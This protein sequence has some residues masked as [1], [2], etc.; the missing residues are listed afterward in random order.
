MEVHYSRKSRPLVVVE[1]SNEQPTLSDS[2]SN[3]GNYTAFDTKM[4]L[5]AAANDQHVF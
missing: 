4:D 1:E 3:M 2:S 5:V